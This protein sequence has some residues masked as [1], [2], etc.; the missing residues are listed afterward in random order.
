L[1]D[2]EDNTISVQDNLYV[3]N[4][5]VA[6]DNLSIGGNISFGG[7]LMPDSAVCSNNQVLWRAGAN[8]WDCITLTASGALTGKCSESGG[9]VGSSSIPAGFSENNCVVTCT[10][11]AFYGLND[12]TGAV[13][14]PS[15]PATF[16][17]WQDKCQYT[18]RGDTTIAGSVK[19]TGKYVCVR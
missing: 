3:A 15:G 17:D 19:I 16:G 5:I 13:S 12:C 1:S 2:P 18:F 8:N 6:E 11:I 14:I 10:S 9:G 4:G 7:E